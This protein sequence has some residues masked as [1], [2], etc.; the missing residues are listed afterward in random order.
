VKELLKNW[1]IGSV[2]TIAPTPSGGGRTW[3]VKTTTKRDFVLKGSDLLRS[4]REYGVLLG[5]SKTPIPVAL[6]VTSVEGDWYA[7]D[8]NGKVYCLYPRLPG[9]VVTEHYAGDA[10]RRALGFGQAIGLLHTCLGERADV[11]GY[12]EME[13]V[14]QIEEWAI[15][16][17]REDGATV[18]ACA[19]EQIWQDAQSEL[20]PLYEELPQQ[21]I[22]RDAH[23]SNMLFSAGRLTG[24]VDFE[25]VRRGPRVFDVCYCG[26]SI[27]VGGF[28]DFE[29]GQKWPS[30]FHSLVRGYEEFCLLTASE[31]LAMYGVFVTIELIFIAFSLDTHNEDAARTNERLLYWLATH[32]GALAM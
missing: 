32:R 27:L 5:L 26:S 29:K 19:I 6:P 17:I 12:E 18:D 14:E 23:P 30:L 15:R 7:K 28:E 8:R 21:L 31:R 9:R 3:F 20:K 1:A 24:F 4:E 10:E 22:H 13:L 11:N 2:D 25:M 16:R